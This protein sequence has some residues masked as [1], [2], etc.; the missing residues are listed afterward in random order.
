MS[1]NLYW[2]LPSHGDG[3]ALSRRSGGGSP[4]RAP[5]LTYLAQVGGAA[6]QL[7]FAGVLVPAGMFCEDPWLV[8]AAVAQRT[9]RLRFMVA[10]RPSLISPML[11]AQMAATG[12]RMT[13]N[14]L[15][16]NVV[17]GGDPDEQARYGD[18]LDHEQRYAQ[19]TEFLTIVRGAWPGR[20]FDFSGAYFRVKGAVVRGAPAVPR[21]FV[22]GSSRAA[23][24]V[25]ARLG[26]VYL[27]WGEVPGDLREL[28]RTAQA[29]AGE[30]GRELSFGTRF[31]VISRDNA[32]DA[33]AVAHQML[34]D[35]D[36]A[37]VEAAQ[38]RSER[39]ESVGQRRMSALHGGG[40]GRLEVYPNVWAGYG[41][42]RPGPVAALVGSH[43]EVADR[44][45]EFYRFGT[46]YMILSGQPHLEEAYWFGEGVIP[47]LQA[48]G[49]LGT[50]A[51]ITALDPGSAGR[52][53]G[54]RAHAASGKR[55]DAPRGQAAAREAGH[56]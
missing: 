54:P 55:M 56:G 5:D 24:Q 34:E 31:H 7:G 50:G 14:R 19:A 35:V 28:F 12:Q 37:M 39:S 32:E 3:R 42:L 25:A 40:A 10:L 1:L 13:G 49:V 29:M 2:F 51:G 48:R 23:Q 36:P 16:L 44:I 33:W 9:T 15:E 43:E 18:W 30:A 47:R 17:T 8:S 52:P 38:A 22:G 41:L 6:E 46:R 11:A 20:P 53:A 26:D 4:Q 21:L 45:E 27:A